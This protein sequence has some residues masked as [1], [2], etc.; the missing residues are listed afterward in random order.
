MKKILR[1]LS[2]S[3]LAL[4]MSSVLAVG[5]PP[6]SH[7]NSA[8]NTEKKVAT[9]T[10][11]SKEQ[12]SFLFVIQANKA[13][14]EKLNDPNYKSSNYRLVFNKKDLSHVIKFSD[15]PKRIVKTITGK[16]L[17]TLWKTGKNSFEKDPPNAVL[18]AD[19]LKALIVILNGLEITEHYVFIPFYIE[20][21]PTT[22]YVPSNA[23]NLVLTVDEK[24][25]N[26]TC[27]CYL[28]NKTC[29]WCWFSCT[30]TPC[31]KCKGWINPFEKCP[32]GQR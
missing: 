20:P 22:N 3:A 14:I 30:E 24:K 6:V 17:Q 28:A 2:A 11:A 10:N 1:F 26:C 21:S 15:R 25:C 12:P 13:K 8:K 16:K 18:S 29:D 31:Q 27:K 32:K 9:K 7:H 5:S 23:N 4:G 19:G